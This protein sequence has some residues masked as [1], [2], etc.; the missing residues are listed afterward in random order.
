MNS[1]ESHLPELTRRQEEILAYIV[2]AYT[3]TPEPVSSKYLVERFNLTYSS[4]TIRNEMVAL[5]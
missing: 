5:L 4:A 3:D 2:K 1:D